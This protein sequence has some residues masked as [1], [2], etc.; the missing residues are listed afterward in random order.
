MSIPVRYIVSMT[1]SRLTLCWPFSRT[2]IR[3][4]FDRSYGTHSIAFD[5]RNLHESPIPAVLN[6]HFRLS[7]SDDLMGKRSSGFTFPNSA[8][9]WRPWGPTCARRLAN[10]QPVSV[11]ESDCW[12]SSPKSTC[13]DHRDSRHI[14]HHRLRQA[15]N[16]TRI[17]IEE[18]IL[19]SIDCVL[20]ASLVPETCLE[21]PSLPV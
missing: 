3:Q 10:N 13:C 4:A 18:F 6:R 9:N 16:A 8:G 19:I 21:F 17:N 20:D 2:A 14:G 15:E 7:R 5:A 1:W 12:I 11:A